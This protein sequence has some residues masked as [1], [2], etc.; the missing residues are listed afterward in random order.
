[1]INAESRVQ[2][3]FLWF[4]VFS[5]TC[6]A[7]GM[8]V[9]VLLYRAQFGS[10]LAL[11]SVEWSNF[12]GYI[13]GIF[14]PVISFVTLLA[15]LQTVYMQREL[16]D[17][18]KKEFTE[19][20]KLQ[21]D[22]ALKQDEQLAHAKSESD[23]ARVQAYQTTILNVVESFSAEFRLESNEMLAAA[24]KAVSGGRPFLDGVR[25]EASYKARAN[26]ARKKV[27]AFKVLAV[28][29]SVTEFEGIQEVKAKF[30]PRMLEIINGVEGE[31]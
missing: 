25:E 21:S 28:E 13:G 8:I 11:T 6:V 3:R 17:T 29:L 18:Q 26:E 14:G 2:G 1:M 24:E 7:L 9:A 15:V 4:L 23:R 16:L 19:L 31:R 5:V 27:A 30:A 20:L 10:E 22:A 12:G